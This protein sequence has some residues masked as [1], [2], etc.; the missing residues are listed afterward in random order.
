MKVSASWLKEYVPVDMPVSELADKLTMAGL[1]VDSVTN[2]YQYLDSVETGRIVEIS[3]HPKAEKLKICSVN[4]GAKTIQVVCGAPNAAQG[5]MAACA[6]PGTIFP[7]G[8]VLQDTVIRGQASQGM[9]CSEKELGLGTDGSGILVLDPDTQPGVKLPEALGLSDAVI[10]IDL[11]PNRPDCLSMIG[12][13]R[14]AAAIQNVPLRLPEQTGFSEHNTAAEHTRVTIE[15]PELCPRYAAR[16]I[17][18][19]AVAP[20][21]P[22]LQDRLLSVGL[23]PI[24]NI[25]DITNFVMME[26]GQPLH[27]FD[28]DRLADQRIVVREAD[29]GEVFTTLDQKERRLSSGMLLIC[30][31]EKPVALAGIMGGLNSEI[32]DQT[33]RVLLESAYFNP[34]SIRKTAKLLGLGTDASHRFERG[35]DPEGTVTAIN[36]AAA[37]M[38]DIGKGRLIEG[39]VD[40]H[41]KPFEPRSIE[42]DINRAN[43]LLGLRLTRDEMARQLASIDFTVKPVDEHMLVVTPPTFRVDVTRPEDLMEEVA[44][45]SGYDNIP[46]TFPA[47]TA[48]SRKPI[49][50]LVWRDAIKDTMLGFGFTEAINYSFIP[51]N[52]CDRL[53]LPENDSRRSTVKILNPLTEDQAEMRSTMIPGLLD[54]MLRNVSR[55]TTTLKLFEIGKVFIHKADDEQPDEKDML[56]AIWTGNSTDAAWHSKG[57]E[58]DFYDMKGVVEGLLESL[59]LKQISFTAL[60]AKECFYTKPGYSARIAAADCPIGIIGEVHPAVLADYGLKQTAYITELDLDQLIPCIPSTKQYRPIPRFPSISR[61]ITMI[62]DETVETQSVLSAVASAE[63]HLVQ[64]VVLFDV[65]RGKPVPE[66][67]KSISF[68]IVYRSPDQT[69]EDAYINQIHADIGSRLL[70]QFNADLP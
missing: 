23:R 28:F 59:R 65:Y 43:Q 56:T 16:L 41:P 64:K 12:I 46:T 3:P 17:F 8:N 6:L 50:A 27:A 67:R 1:E 7:D 44:R 47:M 45:L 48:G 66:G 31:G 57:R 68:R 69:L 52:A 61:D 4:L 24:N 60:P 33:T 21:P 20:S 5:Q 37:L 38:A 14:E 11:T 10:E 26:T 62:I 55:Q 49:D 51:T 9:L 42:L 34:G 36:R 39:V 70:K 2:R 40:V 53:R 15:S 54:T 19:I 29:K 25:V 35:V 32:S 13:A 22:W 18:D 30:D 58:C 63:N